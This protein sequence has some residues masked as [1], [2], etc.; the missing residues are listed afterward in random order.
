MDTLVLFPVGGLL[1]VAY[2][3]AVIVYCGRLSE[4]SQWVYENSGKILLFFLLVVPVVLGL[5]VGLA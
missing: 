3:V 5:Y 2:L 4:K 1:G